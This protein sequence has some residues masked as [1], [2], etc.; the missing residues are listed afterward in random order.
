MKE[1]FISNVEKKDICLLMKAANL[2]NTK[3]VV[4]KKPHTADNRL[5]KGLCCN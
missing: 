4:K 3:I 1:M 5:I 2:T